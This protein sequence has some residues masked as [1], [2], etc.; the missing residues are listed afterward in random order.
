MSA[1]RLAIFSLIV[2][3]ALAAAGCGGGTPPPPAPSAEPTAA[4]PG[5]EAPPQAQAPAAET[6]VRQEEAAPAKPRPAPA[7]KPAATEP[8]PAAQVVE[9]APKPA[10][11]I[12]VTLPAG[13]PVDLAMVDAIGSRTSKPGDAFR[14]TVLKDVVCEGHV[15]VPQGSTVNGLVTEA[16][17]L[18]KIGGTAK[19][20]VEFTGAVLPSGE[21]L[22]IFATLEQVGKSESGKDAATI[23]GAAAV[24]GLLGRALSKDDKAKGTVLGALAGAAAGGAVAAKTKGQEIE[25]P[26]GTNLVIQTARSLEVHIRP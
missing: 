23:G 22:P 9:E 3:A 4:V 16:V 25:F 5:G 18:G 7:A 10:E 24:G 21:T 2:T 6:P 1:R 17:P 12:V 20:V 13:T 14:A 8:A 11:P 15:V 19:L 26:A